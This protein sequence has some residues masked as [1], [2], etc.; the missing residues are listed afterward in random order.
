MDP[1]PGSEEEGSIPLPCELCSSEFPSIGSH[2]EGF[3]NGKQ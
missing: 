1:I 3:V 2:R